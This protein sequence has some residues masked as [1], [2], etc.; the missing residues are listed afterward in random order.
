MTALVDDFTSTG[1]KLFFHQEAMKN[2]QN[3]KGQPITTHVMLCDHCQHS[4]SFCSVQTRGEDSLAY[5]DV[6]AYLDILLRYSLRGV[7]LS[8]GGNPILYK[9][10]KTGKNFNDI[11]PSKT[12]LGLS[13]VFADIYDEPA[14]P[15]HG[16]VSTQGDLITLDRSKLTPT[17]WA[18]ERIPE[19]TRQIR[20]YI[21]IHKPT[22]C[23]IL[24]NCLE[25]NMIQQRCEQLQLMANE[26]NDGIGEVCFVQNKPPAAPNVCLL[27]FP[28]PVL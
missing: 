7:I 20:H 9:C 19:L 18:S 15:H 2:L 27:G 8:G 5:D 14:D 12:T 16:K 6:L 23:R 26:I 24:P 11:A 4:C 10:K 3:G 1:K 17:R 22:Y 28:H 13:Y 25:P 21:D